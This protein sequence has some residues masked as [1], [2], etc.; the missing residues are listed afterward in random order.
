MMEATELNFLIK[1]GFSD[2]KLVDIGT[3]II[4][5]GLEMPILELFVKHVQKSSF[6]PIFSNFI[7]LKRQLLPPSQKLIV[8]SVPGQI[9]MPK[10]PNLSHHIHTSHIS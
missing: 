4:K 8:A 9:S 6:C 7:V 5:I 2:L 1:F 3:K 10:T